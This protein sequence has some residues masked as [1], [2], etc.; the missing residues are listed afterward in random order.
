MVPNI[1]ERR[2]VVL[3]MERLMEPLKDWLKAFDPP[4]LQEAMKKVLSMEF[5]APTNKFTSKGTFSSHD[6]KKFPKKED[7]AKDK[8]TFLLDCETLNDLRKKKLCF[9][10]K[11]PYDINHDCLMK[12]KGK[13]DHEMWALIED[14]NLDH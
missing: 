2:L 7:K 9:Y 14:S 4:S 1:S 10:C 5:V 6:N 3:F 12:P 13:S 8:S 11:A